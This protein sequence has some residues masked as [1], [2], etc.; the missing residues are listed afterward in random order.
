MSSHSSLVMSKFKI[1][2]KVLV[3]SKDSFTI[4]QQPHIEADSAAAN[5]VLKKLL[6]AT[7]EAVETRKFISIS[8]V[9]NN[10][11]ESEDSEE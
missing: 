10:V 8:P 3:F 9:T 11:Y 1:K 5:A 2:T 6:A 4:A 7:T